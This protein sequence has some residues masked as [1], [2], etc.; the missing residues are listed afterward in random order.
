MSVIPILPHESDISAAVPLD[1]ILRDPE[2]ITKNAKNNV[3]DLVLRDPQSIQ[4]KSPKKKLVIRKLPI[5]VQP[6]NVTWSNEMSCYYSLQNNNDNQKYAMFDFDDCLM[7]LNS[8]TQLVFPEIVGKMRQI[9]KTHRI[10]VL[11]NQYGISKGLT[12]HAVVHDR[13]AGIRT[14]LAIPLDFYYATDKDSYRK[15]MTDMIDLMYKNTGKSHIEFYCGDAAGRA[16]DFAISDRYLS[17]NINIYLSPGI[18]FLQ[19]EEFFLNKQPIAVDT[20]K[21]KYMSFIPPQYSIL[22]T[23]KELFNPGRCIVNVSPIHTGFDG[24]LPADKV[25][26]IMV[27][28]QASGK[29]TLSKQLFPN[30]VYLNNDTIK[31]KSKLHQQFTFAATHGRNIVIDNTNPNMETRKFYLDIIKPLGYL[32]ICL[33]FGYEKRLSFHLGQLRAQISHSAVK[34]S[35][36]AVH[37]Y[38]K[39]LIIPTL[40]EGFDLVHTLDH[41]HIPSFMDIDALR[42]YYKYKYTLD[43]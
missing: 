43:R 29:S 22:N 25:C 26:V 4:Q 10:V 2:T 7:V 3:H 20:K 11:S 14:I 19:P 15:P 13:V 31:S 33:F 35:S 17:D 24:E 1:I 30:F 6:I 27:G 9:A 21:D 41:L 12:T 5:V 40:A 16:F 32:K 18:K 8:S 23:Y 37:K 38:Y 39:D 36:I 28:P 42:H 34:V